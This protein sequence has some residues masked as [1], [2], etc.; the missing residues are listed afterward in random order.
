MSSNTDSPKGIESKS[1]DTSI[2]THK[3]LIAWFA[4]NSI[5]ANLL[6]FFILIGGFLTIDTINKQNVPSNKN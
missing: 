6:M 1:V 3:G 2:D 5:A 4:R